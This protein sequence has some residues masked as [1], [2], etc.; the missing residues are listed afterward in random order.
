MYPSTHTNNCISLRGGPILAD[1][2]LPK[3]VPHGGQILTR[4]PVLAAKIGPAGP[5]FAAKV[6]LAIIIIIIIIII[7][8]MDK[9]NY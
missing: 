5:I 1:K 3:S 6:V 4:G 2:L 9:Y 8:V 7:N